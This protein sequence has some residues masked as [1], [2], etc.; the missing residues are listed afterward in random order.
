M[1]EG[2]TRRTR[3]MDSWQKTKAAVVNMHAEAKERLSKAQGKDKG[4]DEFL[5]RLRQHTGSIPMFASGSDLLA[6]HSLSHV[7]QARIE[8]ADACVQHSMARQVSL[9]LP[10]TF[11]CDLA[12]ARPRAGRTTASYPRAR[13]C[14]RD[15][16][17]RR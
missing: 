16:S 1:D 13:T 14:Q 17:I 8:N 9:A 6:G 2:R 3:R 12:I 4:K 11:P 7:E 5:S 10:H 15:F